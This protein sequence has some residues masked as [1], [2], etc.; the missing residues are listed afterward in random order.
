MICEGEDQTREEAR[1]GV[2]LRVA[3]GDVLLWEDEGRPVSI[4]SRARPTVNGV[5][6]N[7]VYTPPALRGRGYA[8][9][10][11]AHLSQQELDRGREFCTLFA[12]LANPTS[13]GIYLRIGYEPLGEFIE[14]DLV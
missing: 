5:T 9:A 14:I 3:A 11:V 12:D 8:T 6:I 1:R 13:N 4:A 2:D 10:C 7:F